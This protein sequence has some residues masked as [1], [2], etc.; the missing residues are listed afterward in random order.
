M[1]LCVAALALGGEEEGGQGLVSASGGGPSFLFAPLPA[2][3]RMM[4]TMAR[5]SSAIKV[6][7][8]GGST[9]RDH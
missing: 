5:N 6:G 8:T 4:C 2:G 7:G 1:L 9:G 3:T